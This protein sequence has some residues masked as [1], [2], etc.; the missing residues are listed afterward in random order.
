MNYVASK[1]AQ[2][3]GIDPL[4]YAMHRVLFRM[5]S[6]ELPFAVFAQDGAVSFCNSDAK[7][8]E[9]MLHKNRDRLVGVYDSRARIEDIVAD[10]KGALGACDGRDVPGTQDEANS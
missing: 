4:T 5:M 8:F 10:L 6:G 1:V 7:H 3:R 9:P 2:K